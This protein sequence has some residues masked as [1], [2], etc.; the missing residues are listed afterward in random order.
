MLNVE[1][2]T[3]LI[4]ANVEKGTSLITARGKLKR[5]KLKR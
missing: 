5:W 2:G 1:K 3:S 4:T